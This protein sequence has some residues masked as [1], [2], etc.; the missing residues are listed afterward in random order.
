MSA[1]AQLLQT[2]KSGNNQSSGGNLGGDNFGS[3]SSRLLNSYKQGTYQPSPFEEPKAAP[4]VTQSK[5]IKTDDNVFS[6][7]FTGMKRLGTRFEIGT[8]QAVGGAEISI[9]LL[10]SKLPFQNLHSFGEGATELKAKG[11]ETMKAAAEKEAKF[12]KEN[13]AA[14]GFGWLAEQVAQATPST[15]ASIGIGFAG[16]ILTANPIIG[17]GLGF[18]SSFVQNAGGAY[19]DAKDYGVSDDKAEKVGFVT[20]TASAL[21]ESIPL[22]RL[23]TK[24]PEGEIA[25][26]AI[27]KEVTKSILKQGVLEG[28]TEGMQQLLQ[29]AVKETY[30]KD[31]SLFEGVPE[32]FIVGG[33]M[34]GGSD[35]AV[36][37]IESVANSRKG[38]TEVNVNAPV[39]E[40]TQVQVEDKTKVSDTK[41]ITPEPSGSSP[42][43]DE[44]VIN[45]ANKKI[46]EA[47][48]TPAESRTDEQS[49][50]VDTL[51]TKKLTP[52]QA[53]QTVLNNDLGDTEI[54]NE[55]NKAAAQAAQEGK[56]V[57]VKGDEKGTGVKISVEEKAPIQMPVND[58]AVKDLKT[59]P[60]TT[61]EKPAKQYTVKD[62]R[63]TIFP[64]EEKQPF[65]AKNRAELKTLI[66]KE[67][68]IGDP[69]NPDP[70]KIQHATEKT[71]EI[72]SALL[73][74]KVGPKMLKMAKSL[75]ARLYEQLY[76]IAGV[77]DLGNYKTQYAAYQNIR[78]TEIPQRPLLNKIEERIADLNDIVNNKDNVIAKIAKEAANGPKEK[79]NNPTND[80]NAPGAELKQAQ[81][82]VGNGKLKESMAYKHVKGLI[83]EEAQLDVRYNAVN[84]DDNVQK[85][86]EYVASN[87]K[88][89]LQVSLGLAEPPSG[90]LDTTISVAVADKIRREGNPVL[91]SQVEASL[92]LRRTRGGQENAAL[93]GRVNDDSPY[94]YIKEAMDRKLQHLG[95]TVKTEIVDEFNKAFN[96]TKQ[97]ISSAKEKAI[98]KIDRQ[99]AKLDEIITKSRLKINDAQSILDALTCKI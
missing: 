10:K 37:G 15:L 85:A 44:N 23:L 71:D 60:E 26:K 55:M 61:T 30:N 14:K 18:S 6:K 19:Q 20:G 28:S 68:D 8:Q 59:T 7:I 82:P 84:I 9:G 45:N 49:Q 62:K 41:N 81:K 52:Q 87:P 66:D 69:L 91:A 16:S 58:Q 92:S 13:G 97:G 42:I 50:I 57:V 11:A 77:G 1:S 3:S 99:A 98:Q 43:L 93:R 63:D 75:R 96:K 5:D 65:P 38:K 27:I 86:M 39:N 76:K 80:I 17:L 2:I 67:F 72:Y 51:L 32:S 83:D 79:I 31:Q 36:G 90:I 34:G 89:A 78:D 56:V 29:N 94:T 25:K 95:N 48:D 35:A 47:W 4:V 40:K 74:A 46:K 70:A 88:E 53:V 21:L 24:S 54:G 73:K 22:G 64:K 33:V 12:V